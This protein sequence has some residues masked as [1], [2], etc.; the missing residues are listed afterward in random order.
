ME[1]WNI[2]QMDVKTAFLHAPLQE[3][4][5]IEACD[6]MQ[7]PKGSI[8]K[9]TKSLYGLKQAPRE[10]YL[11]LSQFI[12]AQG[13]IKSKVDAGVYFKG[14]GVNTIIIS[15]YV[16]DI[17][18]FGGDAVTSEILELKAKLDSEFKL[19]DLGMVKNILG[20]EIERDLEE[21]LIHLG[22]N[23]YINKQLTKFMIPSTPHK[24]KAVPITKAA[25][26]DV[27]N[28]HSKRS[29]SVLDKK[30][31]PFRSLIGSLLYANI[32]SRPDISFALS[33]L[34]SHNADPRKMHWNA[35]L[36]LLRYLRDSQEHK[37]TYGKLSATETRNTLSVYADADFDMDTVGRKSRTGYVIFLN[38]GA[39]A[40][41]SSLQSTVAQSTSEAELYSLVEAV[42]VAMQLQYFLEELGF[43]KVK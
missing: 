1:H 6:G 42:N 12:S 4:N 39:I 34:A 28:A 25:Y 41:N 36:D 14:S 5:Y 23:K 31:Y 10:W 38:G 20:M 15:V 33:T 30:E 9:L 7:I 32:C 24:R 21:N 43:L 19:D 17:L 11:K 13:Y 27:V 40:W 18:I 22:Q 16:D 35:L 37:I 26:A 3:K 8:L 2:F 29:E